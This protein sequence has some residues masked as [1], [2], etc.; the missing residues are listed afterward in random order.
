M[1]LSESELQL[2]RASL[3]SGIRLD[4]RSPLER[5]TAFVRVGEEVLRQ[6]IGASEYEI[7][8]TRIL[9]SVYA[10]IGS[11]PLVKVNVTL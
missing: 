10:M 7:G 8:G 4:G 6:S 1:Q 9:T 5:R 11:E 3:S 2:Y